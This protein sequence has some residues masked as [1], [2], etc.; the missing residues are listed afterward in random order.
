MAQRS[1]AFR[2][3]R[4][5]LPTEEL[6]YTS[7]RIGNIT[8][9]FN[10]TYDVSINFNKAQGGLKSFIDGHGFYDQNDAGSQLA[11]FCSEAVLPGSDMQVAQVDGLRQGISTK[12]ATF[13]RFPDII[14]TY[15]LQTDY[16]T[17]DVFNAWMEYMSPSSN[18][19]NLSHRRMKYP[20]TY[21]CDMEITAFSKAI[22]DNFSKL[23]QTSRFNNVLPS[24]IT[25]KLR[26]VFPSSIIAAPLAYGRAEL[27]KT[28]I[29][30]KYDEYFI[31][32][33]S[34]VGGTFA[35]SVVSDRIVPRIDI[36]QPKVTVDAPP[37]VEGG[38]TISKKNLKT[39]GQL[40]RADNA[41]Y[42]DTFPENSF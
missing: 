39:T 23:N 33:T 32:R 3:G 30:F 9:A 12:Y 41:Q 25:Y 1:D 8:P 26:N 24:S 27:I 15:Y 14:L 40:V 42:G 38:Y 22:K 19:E 10:N 18:R 2:S 29:T 7:S 11:L 37:P 17:N 13:R 36:A 6:A 5:Y 34:R 28:S 21:K 20:E 4:F 35:E 16:Y 31:D